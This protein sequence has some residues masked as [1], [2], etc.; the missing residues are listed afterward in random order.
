MLKRYRK[1]ARESI[2][3]DNYLLLLSSDQKA[4]WLYQKD[5]V[6]CPYYMLNHP[7]Y[8]DLLFLKNTISFS[9]CYSWFLEDDKEYPIRPIPHFKPFTPEEIQTLHDRKVL[10]ECNYR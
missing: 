9:Q 7:I 6:W 5:Q 1:I 2:H 10:M 8:C 4:L 3:S